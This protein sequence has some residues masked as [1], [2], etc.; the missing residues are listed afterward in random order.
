MYQEMGA[1]PLFTK[2]KCCVSGTW[3]TGSHCFHCVLK[4]LSHSY[5]E[6]GQKY[7]SEMLRL[8]GGKMRNM[9]NKSGWQDMYGT[10]EFHVIFIDW[11]RPA[12]FRPPLGDVSIRYKLFQNPNSVLKMLRC[13]IFIHKWTSF[14]IVLSCA[15]NS[16]LYLW[17][18]HVLLIYK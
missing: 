7:Q 12:Y 18:F 6:W 3:S 5:Y 8:V 16:V 14:K 13:C 9:F 10:C 4:G 2:P 11:V 17:C 15:L 1:N